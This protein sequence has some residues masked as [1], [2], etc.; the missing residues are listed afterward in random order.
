MGLTLHYSLRTNLRGHAAVK[1]LVAQLREAACDLP[2]AEVE[3]LVEYEA[4]A[5]V[6]EDFPGGLFHATQFVSRGE[7]WS[8]LHP[9]RAVAFR[10]Q[11]GDG[12]ESAEFGLGRYPRQ[13]GWSWKG[14]CKTQYASAPQHGGVANFLRC[15]VGLVRLLDRASELGLAVDVSDEGGYWERRDAEALVKEI[16]LWNELIAGFGGAL[17]D[18]FPS[19]VASPIFSYSDFERLEA[20]ARVPRARKQH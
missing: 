7:T 5:G 2:F 14:F 13:A 8:E 9:T 18:A 4:E 11:P 19:S 3:P 6:T 1:R 20:R 12:C 15:H 16:G 17:K 10:V